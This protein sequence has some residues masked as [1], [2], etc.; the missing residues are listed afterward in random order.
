MMT[1]G[2]GGGRSGRGGGLGEGGGGGDG[3]GTGGGGQFCG[4]PS[5]SGVAHRQEGMIVV[6]QQTGQVLREKR[7]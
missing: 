5:L 1:G 4:F 3:G 6:F 2:R 7:M